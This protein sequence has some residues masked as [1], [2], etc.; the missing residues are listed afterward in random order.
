MQMRFCMISAVAGL[1]SACAAVQV[2]PAPIAPQQTMA[3]FETRS[4]DSSELK[5]FIEAAMNET[6]AVWPPSEWDLN[7]LTLAALYYH[8]DLD[9]ARA[10]WREAQAAIITA[11]GR[12]NPDFGF[13]ASFVRGDDPGVIPWILQP[14]VALVIETG[15]FQVHPD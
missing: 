15:H 5:A 1:A 14:G 9:V 7:S 8:P 13:T 2:P 11:G 4:F 10:G 3:V 6:A 12:P